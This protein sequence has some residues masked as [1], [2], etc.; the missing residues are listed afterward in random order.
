MED[1]PPL[2][3][4]PEM[5]K[6]GLPTMRKSLGAPLLSEVVQDSDDGRLSSF[7]GS[8]LNSPSYSPSRLDRHSP[9]SPSRPLTPSIL[10]PSTSSELPYFT[11]PGDFD[12]SGFEDYDPIVP[13]HFPPS[14]TFDD[15]E[16][17]VSGSSSLSSVPSEYSAHEEYIVDSENEMTLGLEVQGGLGGFGAGLGVGLRE[18]RTETR[19]SS[20]RG[21]L[22][23]GRRENPWGGAGIEEEMGQEESGMDSDESGETE[24]K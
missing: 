11:S 2:P 20:D 9:S 4:T 19:C 21:T 23:Q 10:P 17:L 7:Y 22:G 14:P 24:V 18:F 8:S 16:V 13:L 15:Q 6:A 1:R 5:H 12:P 3:P